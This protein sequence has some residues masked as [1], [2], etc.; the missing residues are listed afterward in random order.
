MIKKLYVYFVVQGEEQNCHHKLFSRVNFPKFKLFNVLSDL[1]ITGTFKS[2][3]MLTAFPHY[4][5]ST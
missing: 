4:I 1:H 2:T 3:C 5:V